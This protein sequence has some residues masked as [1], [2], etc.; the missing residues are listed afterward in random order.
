MKIS[1]SL[2]LSLCVFCFSQGVAAWCF[3]LPDSTT[4]GSSKD[5]I[6]SVNAVAIKNKP[7][8]DDLRDGKLI[9]ANVKTVLGFDIIFDLEGGQ[10]K[11]I[12]VPLS[13]AIGLTK[14]NTYFLVKVGLV[15]KG[16]SLLQ[17]SDTW[18]GGNWPYWY[19][20]NAVTKETKAGVLG[21]WVRLTPIQ[22]ASLGGIPTDVSITNITQ[23]TPDMKSPM[24]FATTQ[25]VHGKAS[26]A[27]FS[28]SAFSSVPIIIDVV[29]R[30]PDVIIPDRPVS[31]LV[32][33]NLKWTLKSLHSN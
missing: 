8:L 9:M 5:G 24:T 17:D 18:A 7:S 32:G 25:E 11:T 28:S 6:N 31:E 12:H 1:Y 30:D 26:E 3:L 10:K 23:K 15:P 27:P 2:T 22:D 29:D 33:V 14:D 16:T 21:G 20:E 19:D 13:T 4:Y